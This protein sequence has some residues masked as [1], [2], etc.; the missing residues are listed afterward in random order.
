MAAPAGSVDAAGARIVAQPLGPTIMSG[1]GFGAAASPI[2]APMVFG[3]G[4]TQ[5]GAAATHAPVQA[6]FSFGLGMLAALA[7]GFHR[8]NKMKNTATGVGQAPPQV[9]GPSNATAATQNQLPAAAVLAQPAQ[10]HAGLPQA[11]ATETKKQKV[12][13]LEVRSR[14]TCYQ[15]LYCSTLLLHL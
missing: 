1:R 3:A 12:P 15:G 2:A 5:G 13:L 10:L 14:Y 4:V 7:P 11:G 9:G 8:K 6:G